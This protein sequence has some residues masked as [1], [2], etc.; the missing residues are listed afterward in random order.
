LFLHFCWVSALTYFI[1][2]IRWWIIIFVGIII[3]VICFLE[4]TETSL[5][6]LTL[7]LFSV[8]FT[9]WGTWCSEFAFLT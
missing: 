7:T 5:F 4:V 8:I 3:F 9:F 6:G 2:L 1:I